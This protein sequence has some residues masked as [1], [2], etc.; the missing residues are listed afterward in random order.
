MEAELI[1]AAFI[2][3]SAVIV[4]ISLWLGTLAR[5]LPVSCNLHK[6]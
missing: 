3:Y 1:W 2:Y 6:F 4:D 5:G